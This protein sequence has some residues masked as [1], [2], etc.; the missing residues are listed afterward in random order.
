MHVKYREDTGKFY[1]ATNPTSEHHAEGCVYDKYRAPTSDD[2]PHDTEET[3]PEELPAVLNLGLTE[4]ASGN[5][6]GQVNA[7]KSSVRKSLLYRVIES[8]YEQTFSNYLHTNKKSLF[9]VIK[10]FQESEL[11]SSHRQT[12]GTSLSK[13]IFFGMKGLVYARQFVAKG[14]SRRGAIWLDLADEAITQDGSLVLTQDGQRNGFKSKTLP[15]IPNTEGPYLVAGRLVKNESGKSVFSSFLILPIL[16]KDVVIPVQSA[17]HRLCGIRLA[18]HME[19]KGNNAF[20]GFPFEPLKLDGKMGAKAPIIIGLK[21][22]GD[23]KRYIVFESALDSSFS[24]L[25]EHKYRAKELSA[26]TAEHVF[27]THLSS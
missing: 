1:L 3:E 11:A 5:V 18:S 9:S 16:S 13:S 23:K 27:K 21:Q 20:I 22:A 7:T 2:T 10:T 24:R 12:D 26:V 6:S 19:A 17:W 15:S 14:D 8:L 4:S 25:A